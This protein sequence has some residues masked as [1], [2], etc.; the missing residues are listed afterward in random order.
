MGTQD[1]TTASAPNH[2]VTALI[3][4]KA[5]VVVAWLSVAAKT[6]KTVDSSLEI[7]ILASDGDL[8]TSGS[9]VMR[10][11]G[12]SHSIIMAEITV[13]N[14]MQR[15]SGTASLTRAFVNQVKGSNAKILDTRKT[16][17]GLKILENMLCDVTVDVIIDL[18]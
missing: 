11:K 4:A 16:T 10:I 2:H 12:Y 3:I 18:P 5:D 15:L 17:P 9:V 13:L 6:F 14:I 1:W 8:V 7:T